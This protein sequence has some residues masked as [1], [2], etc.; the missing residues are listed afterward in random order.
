MDLVIVT[1]SEVS[2]TQKD[3]II[4]YRLDV[5]STKQAQMT[6]PT[7]QEWSNKCRKQTYDY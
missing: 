1:L 2:E 7:K 4:W 5:E 3:L 6:L